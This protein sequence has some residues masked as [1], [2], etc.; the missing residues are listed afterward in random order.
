MTTTT[1]VGHAVLERDAW[2]E[3]QQAHLLREKELTRLRDALSA[4]RRALPWLEITEG[5]EFDG[6]AVS[7]GD[8]TKSLLDLFEGRRQLLIY[9]FM[10]GPDWGAE[11]CPTC[12]FWADNFNDVIVHL[13]HRDTSMKV[14]SRATLPQ[15]EAYQQRMGWDFDW[16]SS[17]RGNFN[18]DMGVSHRPADVEAGV[19]RYNF[20]TQEVSGD[21]SPGI[22]AFTRTDDG[23]IFLTYQTFSRG[24]ELVNGAYHLL[25]LTS[26]GRDED[27]LPWSQSWLRRHDA[28]ED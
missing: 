17:G 13:E 11:G 19:A 1:N 7:D 2:L 3:A 27:G 24:L 28:Y 9:H 5:Y 8:S 26:K 18:L 23:R 14:V 10:Y 25:D 4:E 21:E 22:S 6:P 15:I 12:S 20:G 16:Y